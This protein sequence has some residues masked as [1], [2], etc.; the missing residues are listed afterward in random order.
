[1][2]LDCAALPRHDAAKPRAALPRVRKAAASP[3]GSQGRCFSAWQPRRPRLRRARLRRDIVCHTVS[4]TYVPRLILGLD[5]TRL[6]RARGDCRDMTRLCRDMT[7]L[8][9]ARG[10]QGRGFAAWPAASR[11]LARP[12]RVACG[13]AA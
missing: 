9:R 7:R 10:S 13:F 5:Y 6:R 2:A 1:M 3:A 4:G 11:G 12:R 8:R